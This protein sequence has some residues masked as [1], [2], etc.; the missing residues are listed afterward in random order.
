MRKLRSPEHIDLQALHRVR[1][2]MMSQRTC[3]INQMR[4]FCLEYGIAIHQGAGKFKADLPRVLADQSNDLTSAMRRILAS[5][6]DE[7]R[8]LERKRSSAA[9]LNGA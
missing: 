3:L 1:D 2:R 9:L 5:T 7:L 6:F 4:A 8:Q